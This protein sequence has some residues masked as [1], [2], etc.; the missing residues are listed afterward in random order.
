MTVAQ[1]LQ[2]LLFPPLLWFCFIGGIFSFAVG[3][4]LLFFSSRMYALFA[5]MNSWVS[6]RKVSRPMALPRDSWPFFERNRRV[7]AVVFIAASILSVFNLVWLLDLDKVV[8]VV[9]MKSG[10][11]DSFIAWIVS[12]LWWL[13]LFGSLLTAVVGTALGFF[14]KA[15]L[16]MEQW[17]NRWYSSRNVAKG[18]DDMLTPLDTLAQT[19]PR[20]LGAV[21]ATAAL[22]CV[23]AI[24]NRLF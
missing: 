18:A 10:L 5:V 14:P 17:S 22:G 2:Q 23:I 16:A 13:L 12:S 21:I 24:G 15:M 20:P 9:R 1:A 11:P 4:G 19:H 8:Q 3:I 7:I 6:F